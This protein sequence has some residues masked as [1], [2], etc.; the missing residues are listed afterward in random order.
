MKISLL[1][2]DNSHPVNEWLA[3]WQSRY[4]NKHN[5]E[6]CRDKSELTG[7]DLLFLISCSQIVGKNIREMY[8]YTLVLHGSDLPVGRGWSPHIWALL[9]GAEEVTVSLL[10]AEDRVDT[11]NIWSKRSFKVS[12]DMLYDEINTM[13]FETELALLDDA[14]ELMSHENPGTPQRTDITPTYYPKRT[15]K[16]SEV[17]PSRPLSELFNVIR[18]ADPERYP[19]YFKMH[20]NIYT[21]EIKKVERNESDHDK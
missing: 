11:G 21:I 3:D 18:L 15:P 6:I 19:A 7:G 16:D 2:T 13:L 4:N 14:L 8:S 17:D 5:V 9:N 20:G 10:E 12:N 1:C